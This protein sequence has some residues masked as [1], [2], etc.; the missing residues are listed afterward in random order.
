MSLIELV[1]KVELLLHFA[2][3]VVKH[4]KELRDE[5]KN[6]SDEEDY[7]EIQ[8]ESGEEEPQLKKRK[9]DCQEGDS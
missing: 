2:S 7:E 3:S 8:E 6:G 5:I 1:T 9:K 4:A